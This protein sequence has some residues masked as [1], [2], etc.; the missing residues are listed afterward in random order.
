MTG[1]FVPA[2]TPKDVVELLQKEISAIVNKPDIKAR[3]LELGVVAEGDTS[4]HFAA[5]VKDEIAKWKT[6]IEKAHISKI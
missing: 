3:L 4:A 5:Y 2:G 1:V 6:V